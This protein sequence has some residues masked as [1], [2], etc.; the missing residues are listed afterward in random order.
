MLAK[1]LG[2]VDPHETATVLE[3]LDEIS[4][5]LRGLQNSLKRKLI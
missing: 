3:T 5:M 2:Y 1:R 4:R